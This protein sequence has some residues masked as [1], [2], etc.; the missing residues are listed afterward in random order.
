MPW[1]ESPPANPPRLP[2]EFEPVQDVVVGWDPGLE[3]F[4]IDVIA[5]L[6]RRVKVTLVADTRDDPDDIRRLL[7]NAGVDLENVEFV[8]VPTDSI[9]VRDFGPRVVRTEHGRVAVDFSY[10]GRDS[11]DALSAH[12]AA[13]WKLPLEQ[14]PIEVEGGNLLSNGRGTC[15]T[16]VGLFEQ[17]PKLSE[18]Q[19]RAALA[20]SLG[21]E[22][23]LILPALDGEATGHV[24]MY[25]SFTGPRDVLVGRYQPKDD[26]VNA[27]LLDR[28]AAQLSRAGFRVRRLP[29]PPDDDQV[30]RTY[31][32]ATPVND[33]VLVPVYMDT[34]KGEA[35]ALAAWAAAYPGR[36]IIPIASSELIELE[37]A[38]HC[39]TLS[40]GR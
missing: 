37:G 26:P 29:M 21:C 4:Y 18:H 17:N 19:V 24:D 11:D 2:G 22:H 40:I 13:L 30:F 27:E 39:A 9:W 33:A 7:E 12:L 16:S 5:S 25:A 38:V 14:L 32:N 36:E 35:E 8:S 1:G 6:S 3:G 10:S 34:N 23:L 28:A 20:E 15:I 31:V